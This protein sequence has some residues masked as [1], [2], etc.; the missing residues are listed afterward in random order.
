MILIVAVIVETVEDGRTR[1]QHYTVDTLSEVT[2]LRSLVLAVNQKQPGAHVTLYVDCVSQGMVST[3][4]SMRDMFQKMANPRLQVVSDCLA[5]LANLRIRKP[6]RHSGGHHWPPNTQIRAW[7]QGNAM[8]YWDRFLSWLLVFACHYRTSSTQFP[9][10]IDLSP[11]I[12]NH[13]VRLR[14]QAEQSVCALHIDR[15]TGLFEMTVGVLTTCHI[16]Y[17]W[18]SSICIFYLTEQHSKFLLHTVQVLYMCTYRAHVRYVTKTSSVV[19]LNK[20]HIYCYLKCIVY[21]K[22]LKPRQSF[23]ITLYF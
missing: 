11:M 16:Q 18:D 2:I 7:S 15:Y 17:T 9:H 22:L 6:Y 4:R 14:R 5:N 23:R 12:Y 1:A 20:K 8:W 19:L 21:D 3:P 13:E 10:F